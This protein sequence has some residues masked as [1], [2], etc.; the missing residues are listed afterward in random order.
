LRR[1][2][3]TLYLLVGACAVACFS[4]LFLTGTPKLTSFYALDQRQTIR[5]PTLQL[6]I[7]Y[8]PIVAIWTICNCVML[9]LAMKKLRQERSK[10]ASPLISRTQV[11]VSGLLIMV[12]LG[13]LDV[14]FFAM[15]WVVSFASVL[16]PI[17][18]GWFSLGS[19]VALGKEIVFAETAEREL[20]M[21][22][23][24]I[25]ERTEKSIAGGMA[26]EIKN[27]LGGPVLVLGDVIDRDVVGQSQRELQYIK[28][29][30]ESSEALQH[31][32]S[33]QDALQ[34]LQD[35]IALSLTNVQRGV[36]VTSL[37]LDYTKIDSRMTHTP[38]DMNVLV[39]RIVRNEARLR[40]GIQLDFTQGTDVTACGNPQLFYVIAHNLI[41]NAI[42]AVES[43]NGLEPKE[44]QVRTAMEVQEGVRYCVLEVKDNG[45]GI[46]PEHRPRIFDPFF[47]TKP[48]RG[49][50]LGL[51]LV[52]RIA[53]GYEGTAELVD[54]EEGEGTTFRVRLPESHA[55]DQT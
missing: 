25:Q 47:S 42:D 48:S 45:M 28:E 11:V 3:V 21:Q 44:I 17:G 27:A 2:A 35:A 14:V 55:C 29:A 19:A 53:E 4:P 32:Q 12:T 1:L 18:W 33:V 38:V 30:C 46:K 10:T 39:D 36:E 22:V 8:I 52:R 23:R 16:Y 40:S 54:T 7:L 51:N 31:I 9:F 43:P 41:V 50:G 20:Q 24:Q 37:V 6:G 49:T 13:A 15:N 26:H 5:L 34:E